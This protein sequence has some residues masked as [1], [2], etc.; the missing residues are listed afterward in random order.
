MKTALVTGTSYGMGEAIARKLLAEDWK[1]YGVSRSKGKLYHDNFRWIKCDLADQHQIESCLSAI[2][3]NSLDAFISNAGVIIVEDA[4]EV[5]RQAYEATFSVNVLAP[6][7][8]VHN[9]KPKIKKATII[10][11]SSVADRLPE[12]AIALY[13]SSKAANTSYFNSLAQEL[14][15]ADVIT[16]LPDYVE[17]PMLHSTMD[18]DKTFDWTCT[19][20]PDDIAKLCSDIINKIKKIETGSN[21][22]VVTEALK[23]DLRD[24]EKLCSFNTDTQQLATLSAPFNSFSH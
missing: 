21:I 14:T 22:I 12:P 20:N 16:I 2:T 4:T 19:I 6:M 9:L 18:S 17:T 11:I 3:E 13:C 7:L 8:L 10:S 5:S 15:S 23:E 24:T 1:V